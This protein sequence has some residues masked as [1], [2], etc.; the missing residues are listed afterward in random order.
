M[1]QLLCDDCKKPINPQVDNHISASDVTIIHNG[2]MGRFTLHFCARDHF[3]SWLKKNGEPSGIISISND[4]G[5][6]A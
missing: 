4:R 2:K 6:S 1:I 3:I 5:P